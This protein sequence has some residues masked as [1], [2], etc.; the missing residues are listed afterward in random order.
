MILEGYRGAGVL[1]GREAIV[2]FCFVGGVI[3]E[4]H[5]GAGVLGGRGGCCQVLF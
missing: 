4:G 5:R 1:G 3:L 2:K